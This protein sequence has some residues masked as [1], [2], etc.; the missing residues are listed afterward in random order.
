MLDYASLNFIMNSD[1]SS[2]NIPCQIKHLEQSCSRSYSF[3]MCIR[4]NPCPPLRFKAVLMCFTV[5]I[6]YCDYLPA[7]IWFSDIKIVLLCDKYWILW[8][9]WPCPKVVKI[10][11][12]Y[13]SYFT[14]QAGRWKVCFQANHWLHL[15]RNTK[16]FKMSDI[17][18]NSD[19]WDIATLLSRQEWLKTIFITNFGDFFFGYAF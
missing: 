6:G 17:F 7:M 4:K 8:L 12:T 19:E 3:R 11:G 1:K 9:F 5:G 13:C 10:S 14:E 15:N 2:N 18:W 16:S